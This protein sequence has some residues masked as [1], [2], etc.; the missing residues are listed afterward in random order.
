MKLE[1]I[2][3]K[4]L[5]LSMSK[6]QDYTTNSKVDNHEN[7]KR[8]AEI[9][10]WFKHDKDKSYAILIGTKLARL[11]AL[12]SSGAEPN[13]ESIEDSFVDLINYCSL[14]LERISEEKDLN[15]FVEQ[16]VESYISGHIFLG[17]EGLNI[18][19]CIICE[20]H[21]SRHLSEVGK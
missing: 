6:R 19:F 11:G 10:S 2:F 20:Q 15:S 8:S 13:N 3:E 14:W 21:I 7:F 1:Q 17:G 4:C 12:L 16:K 9:A 5:K 18:S